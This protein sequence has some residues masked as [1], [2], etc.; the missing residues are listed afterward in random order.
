MGSS[1]RVLPRNG[2]RGGLRWSERVPRVIGAFVLCV[3]AV[4][5]FQRHQY[6]HPGV[7]LLIILVICFPWVLD[8]G[9]WPEKFVREQRLE[10]PVM[11]LWSGG[12]LA[13]VTWL[14]ATSHDPNDFAPFMITILVGQMA[15]T[16]GA[17]FGAVVLVLGIGLA[18]AIP[19]FYDLQSEDLWSFAYTIGWIGGTG[20]RRQTQIA[21]ELEEAQSRLTEQAAEEERHRLARDIHDLI[22]HSLAVTMLQLT[23]ARLALKGGDIDEALAALEDAEA[24]GRAAMAEI[25]RTVGLLGS[26]DSQG[27]QL[28]TPSAADLTE[29]VTGFR[30]AGLTVDFSVVGDLNQVP[31]ATGFAAYRLV[32][33]ALSNA[34]KH[35]PG[36]PVRL[37]IE[38]SPDNIRIRVV[39]PVPVTAGSRTVGGNGIRGMTERAEM[40]GGVVTAGNVGGTWNVDAQLPWDHV[41]R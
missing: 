30:H 2:M 36:A 20:Y 14:T 13:G 40:L 37:L 16:M 28:P 6:T 32:Q 17:R 4:I 8:M 22:A 10:F 21:Y 41:A 1:T 5:A 19:H 34:V 23:G 39:N 25:H 12:V 26:G 35:A 18:I 33:E 7:Q 31:L 15:A 38:V 3:C 24:A 29:L 27:T 9:G 11:V